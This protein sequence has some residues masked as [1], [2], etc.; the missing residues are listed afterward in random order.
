MRRIILAI[1]CICTIIF[2]VD[3]VCCAD[4]EIYCSP[5]N[6]SETLKVLCQYKQD[7]LKIE[8][9]DTFG[10]N[11][12]F[13]PN[14]TNTD[15]E[16]YTKYSRIL[17]FYI[18]DKSFCDNSDFEKTEL[19]IEY[20]DVGHEHFYLTYDSYD[21]EKVY[22]D[23]IELYDSGKI[24]TAVITLDDARF[25]KGCNAG[26]ISSR[27]NKNCDFTITVPRRSDGNGL[28]IYSVKLKKTGIYGG[29]KISTSDS[30]PGNIFFDGTDKQLE[31]FFQNRRND[32]LNMNVQYSVLDGEG[33]VCNQSNK[34][35]SVEGGNTVSDIVNLSDVKEYGT[36]T[37]QV[38][39]QKEGLSVERDIPF[40]ICVKALPD[41]TNEKIGIGTHFSWGRDSKAGLEIIK[42]IGISNIRDGYTWADFELQKKVYTE[43]QTYTDYLANADE[44]GFNVLV[45]AAYGNTLYDMSTQHYLPETDEQIQA[46][47]DYVLEM[48]KL[49]SD[50]IEVVE[51]WN[52]PDVSTY[53]IKSFD[54][55]ETYLKLLQAVSNAVRCEYPALKIAG[56]TLS[57]ATLSKKTDWLKELLS[58]SI[59]G[60]DGK[61]H[62]ASEYFDVITIHHYAL[63]YDKSIKTTLETLAKVKDIFAQ[64][65]CGDKEIYHTEFGASHIERESS[66]KTVKHDLYFQAE[67]LAR[68]YLGLY[69]SNVGDRYYIYDF[70]NDSLADNILSLNLG[71]V[72]SHIADV[73]YY[74]KPSLLAISHINKIIGTKEATS[75]KTFECGCLHSSTRHYGYEIKYGN[76]LDDS[77]ITALF[78]DSE[79]VLYTFRTDGKFTEFFDLYG[80]RLDNI[81]VVGGEC[82]LTIGKSPIF[83]KTYLT[84]SQMQVGIENKNVVLSGRLSKSGEAVTLKVMN[85]EDKIVFINETETNENGSFEFKFEVPSDN[86]TYIALIGSQM[87]GN[88]Y[89]FSFDVSSPEIDLSNVCLK[90][91]K[92][93]TVKEFCSGVPLTFSVEFPDGNDVSFSMIVAYYQNNVLLGTK[94]IYSSDMQ[95]DK[96]KFTTRVEDDTYKKADKVKVF[97]F[98]ST[99]NI[100][101]FAGNLILD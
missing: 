26:T 7:T 33:N 19:E 13:I 66:S 31:V 4:S 51:I 1:I 73:P 91:D 81:L 72:G 78:T 82:T 43:P 92:D 84:E 49:N 71:L 17:N 59:V 47:V 93:I 70:S 16:Y 11:A 38:K 23:Y 86:S 24:K 76:M 12:Y 96:N 22:T 58:T 36:Y 48:L 62:F 61:K 30:V 99:E 88:I 54:K 39:I 75:Y 45:T 74:A 87:L 55:P 14:S 27:E 65:G 10:R 52:E 25:K 94:E 21:G 100:Y 56:P 44:N 68:Y 6:D 89:Y 101:P 32:K 34:T 29:V 9:D 28:L 60:E 18:Y 77:I 98:D 79:D 20:K 80:N 53:N 15:S 35:L 64:Y 41:K 5:D 97:V 83:A 46:Y 95:K 2:N 90:T 67:K 85:R 69:A 37:L 40:S 50:K 63:N 42:N 3:Y 57:S 8:Y